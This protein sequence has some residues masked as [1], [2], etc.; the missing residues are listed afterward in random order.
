MKLQSEGA[1]PLPA[2]TDKT[3]GLF[4]EL[5]GLTLQQILENKNIHAI[6]L[7]NNNYP[8]PPLYTIEKVQWTEIQGSGHP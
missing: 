2:H 6:E 5:E 3:R 1:F 7:C 4:E 8:K